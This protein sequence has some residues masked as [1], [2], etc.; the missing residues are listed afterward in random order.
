M[1]L[2]P[3]RVHLQ[4]E[5]WVGRYGTMYRL[6]FG[7][8]DAV[9]LAEPD[10]IVDALRARPDTWRRF[11]SFES[12]T[13]DMGLHGVFTAEGDDWRRQRRIVMA[14]FDPAHLR[15]FF[16]SLMRV[17]Q[18]LEQRWRQAAACGETL[19]L[20]AQ[21][22]R[23]SV[24][25]TAGLA[26]GV[27]MNTIEQ[28][29][30]PLHAH[31]EQIFPMID[32]RTYVPFAYWRYVRLPAD[33][34]FDRHLEAAHALIRQLIATARTRLDAE[35]TRR[36]APADLLEAMLVARDADGSALSDDEIVANVFTVLLAGEDTTANSLAWVVY[37]LYTHPQAWRALVD[38]ADAMLAPH[39]FAQDLQQAGASRFAD[40]CIQ[41]AMRLHPAAPL[42]YMEAARDAQLRDVA[43]PK[44]TF[45]F[46]LT[47][48]GAVDPM[49]LPDA[50]RYDPW[51]WLGAHDTSSALKRVSIPFGAG[52]RMCPGR[53]LALLEMKMALTMLARRFE[54]IEVGTD[55][56]APPAEQ[57]A[58]TVRPVGLRMRVAE[59]RPH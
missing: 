25:A 20:Q 55:T 10:L 28:Q 49:R 6:R 29:H 37:L 8:R 48:A 32:R 44:G 31:L 33:R 50:Q 16:P 4:L 22:M 39:A 42:H 5:D 54:L 14:A 52:P 45:L 38:E 58:F 18:R 40:A 46:C 30:S 9:V 11:G 51:R 27:D 3:S 36:A 23:F 24:D 53:Y 57:M 2:D 1:Q 13:R 17:T 43:I 35:P 26:F 7:L 12:I 19:D 47:R 41:E 59:R 56:G 15:S 34:A 21:L